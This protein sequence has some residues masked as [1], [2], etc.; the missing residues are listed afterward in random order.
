MCFGYAEIYED[1]GT[2]TREYFE[3][4]DNNCTHYD[5]DRHLA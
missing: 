5:C 1:D 2:I 3:Q 4:D